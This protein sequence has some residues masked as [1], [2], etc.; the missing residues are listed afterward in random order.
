M[1]HQDKNCYD[2]S[3]NKIIYDNIYNFK[4]TYYKITNKKCYHN[5]FKTFFLF[6]KCIRQKNNRNN[7]QYYKHS[8]AL[9]NKISLKI[10]FKGNK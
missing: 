4:D 1:T 7:Y 3:Y 10:F 9:C 6:K 8:K 2:G 5:S